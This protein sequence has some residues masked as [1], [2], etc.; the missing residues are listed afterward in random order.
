MTRFVIFLITS[1]SLVGCTTINPYG[2]AGQECNY[3]MVALY[4]KEPNLEQLKCIQNKW[5]TSEQ[6]NP[7]A[8]VKEKLQIK[9]NEIEKAKHIEYQNMLNMSSFINLKLQEPIS[10]ILRT[11]M[12]YPETFI[13]EKISS[14]C[15]SKSKAHWV[16]IEENQVK[17]YRGNTGGGLVFCSNSICSASN[18]SSAQYA[19]YYDITFRCE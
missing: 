11:P 10:G 4:T 16:K 2:K 1:M 19:N 5:N 13:T 6:Y 14:F 3:D 7:N 9:I 17:E 15:K 18:N 12:G 8:K